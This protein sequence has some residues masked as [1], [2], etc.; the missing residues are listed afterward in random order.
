MEP[1]IMDYLKEVREMRLRD[2]EQQRM[3]DEAITVVNRNH[4]IAV[5]P[6]EGTRRVWALRR[7]GL[8]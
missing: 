8:A 6:C 5:T 1:D 2:Q 4:E 7:L 3:T